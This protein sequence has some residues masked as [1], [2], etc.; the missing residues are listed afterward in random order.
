M[1]SR[2]FL[3][4]S[5]QKLLRVDPLDCTMDNYSVRPAGNYSAWMLKERYIK[6]I[7]TQYSL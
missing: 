4:N 1:D 6:K 2:M 5:D 7:G 3:H